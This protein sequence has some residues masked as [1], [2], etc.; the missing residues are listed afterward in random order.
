VRLPRKFDG[1]HR[2][3]AF[4]DFLTHEEAKAATESL[5][6]THLYGRHLVLEW[7]AVGESL[8]S[9]RTK[10]AQSLGDDH[11]K[12]PGARKRR[13]IDI[14]DDAAAAGAVAADEDGM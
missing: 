10:A 6:S 3:F 9:L 12:E 2:G 4:V 5:A 14:D 7:A 11:S 1:T 13:A 8:D